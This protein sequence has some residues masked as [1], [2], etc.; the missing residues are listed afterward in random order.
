VEWNRE[1]WDN[2]RPPLGRVVARAVVRD[3][4]LAAGPF[5]TRQFSILIAPC[6][7]WNCHGRTARHMR[8]IALGC[9]LDLSVDRHVRV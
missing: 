1:L 6:W 4:T 8:P 7:F 9:L 5:A 3:A 2:A